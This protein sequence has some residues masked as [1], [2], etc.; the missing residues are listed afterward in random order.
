M[1]AGERLVKVPPGRQNCHSQVFH[2]A[3]QRD[4]K[5]G[6]ET[7]FSQALPPLGILMGRQINPSADRSKAFFVTTSDIAWP[8]IKIINKFLSP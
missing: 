5:A 1:R 6:T 7:P 3:F 8:E 2:P 4:E